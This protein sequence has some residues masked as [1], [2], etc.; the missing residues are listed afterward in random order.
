MDATAVRAAIQCRR[1]GRCCRCHRAQ[2]CMRPAGPDHKGIDRLILL[3]HTVAM[4]GIEVSELGG[5]EV[6]SYVEISQPAPGA[7][8][9][10]IKDA[11][12]G[13]G[14]FDTSH[15]APGAGEV[16]IKAEAIGVNFIDPYFGSGLYPRELPIASALIST[17]P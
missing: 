12:V 5:P 16:L 10:L 11:A 17:S 14:Y 4:H 2:R 3:T 9:G 1:W 8:E 7:R 6:L 15:P 13:R